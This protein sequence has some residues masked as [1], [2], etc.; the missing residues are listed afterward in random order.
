MKEEKIEIIKNL[1]IDKKIKTTYDLM[2]WT[3]QDPELE[4][5]YLSNRNKLDSL[6]IEYIK[7]NKIN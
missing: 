3:R 7:T 4:H 6:V 1:I 2:R 5:Y